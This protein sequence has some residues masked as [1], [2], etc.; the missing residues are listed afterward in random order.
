[1][2][3]ATHVEFD[4]CGLYRAASEADLERMPPRPFSLQKSLGQ[5]YKYSLCRGA[6]PPEL[7]RRALET[8]EELW[9]ATAVLAAI[10]VTLYR[11]KRKCATPIFVTFGQQKSKYAMIAPR[12]LQF[13][14]QNAAPH[15]AG[16]K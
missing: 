7:F 2:L 1:M 4:A 6:K 12:G 16:T 11:Q 10:F 5:R 3:Y 13:R 9:D 14:S 8:E 15:R